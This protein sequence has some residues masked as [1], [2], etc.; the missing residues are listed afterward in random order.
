MQFE[1]LRKNLVLAAVPV[2]LSA[3]FLLGTLG[4]FDA[5]ITVFY[6]PIIILSTRIFS[7]GIVTYVGL[8]CVVLTCASFVLGHVEGFHAVRL[9][10]FAAILLAIA[11]STSF[12][13]WI[14]KSG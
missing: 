1:Q 13:V 6:I 3:V 9:D 4:P 14:P 11:A 8:A 7:K 12:S 5:I 10:Q 2:S